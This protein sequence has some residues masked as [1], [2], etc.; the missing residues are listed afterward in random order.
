MNH[1]SHT[2]QSQFTFRL[3]FIKMSHCIQMACFYSTSVLPYMLLSQ[4]CSL[5]DE[6]DCGTVVTECCA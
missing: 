5:R 4:H 2:T 3:F 1:C 6:C